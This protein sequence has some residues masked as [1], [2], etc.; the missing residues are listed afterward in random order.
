MLGFVTAAII[1]CAVSGIGGTVGYLLFHQSS[2]SAL[3][4]WYHWFASD[5]V[6]IVTVA[7]F[8][9]GLVAMAR[10][11]PSLRET[12]EGSVALLLLAITCSLFT[13]MPRAP[14]DD[15]AL[16]SIFPLLLWIAARCRPV[17][18]RQQNS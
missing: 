7:P 18:S 9:I 13:F 11:P 12:V 5:A 1:G 2:A 6:G 10:D 16:V 4:I 17:F 15:I 3:T 14:W 8:V